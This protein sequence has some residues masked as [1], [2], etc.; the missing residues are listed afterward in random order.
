MKV[1]KRNGT[2][3]PWDFEKIHWRIKSMCSTPF[4][5]DFQKKNR[6]DA[7]EIFKNLPELKNADVDLVSS[8]T[9][10]GLY[11]NIPTSDIDLLSAEI[12]QEMCTKHPD[13]SILA[14]RLRV[15]NLQ[16]NTLE[17]LFEHFSH[18]LKKDVQNNIFKYSMMA[19][20]N[21]KNKHGEISP[22]VAPYVTALA[23][24]YADKLE[25]MID[26]SR[27]YSN[28]DYL[29][30]SLLEKGYLFRTYELENVFGCK[31]LIER[32]SVADMRIAIGIVCAPTPCPKTFP[33]EYVLD[34][35]RNHTEVVKSK[36]W[37]IYDKYEIL[38]ILSKSEDP[39]KHKF[40]NNKLFYRLYWNFQLEEA[41]KQIDVTEE[42]WKRIKEIYDGITTGL[43]TPATPTRFSAGTLKPQ[44]SSCFL[45]AME[46]DSLRGIYNTLQ[47]QS[48]ISKHA[49]GIGMWVHNIRSTGSY[50]AG[51]NGI[52]NGLKP[53]LKVYDNSTRYVDQGGGKRKGTVSC[54]LEPWHADILDF[55][56]LKRNL[57]SDDDHARRLF[58]A[59]WTPD[60]FFRCLSVKGD[61]YLFD[62]AVCPKLYDSYDEGYSTQYLSDEYVNEHK[63]LY[64]FTYRYRK[65]IRQGKYEKKI[66]ILDL[67]EEI[68][69][70]IKDAGNPYMLSKDAANRKSNQKNLGVIKSSNLCVSGDT[71]I[72]TK[73]GYFPII[74][75]V[76]KETTIW[77]G[78]EWSDVT[79]VQ[80]G[81]GQEMA[82]I[83]F[84]NGKVITCTPYHKF[85]INKHNYKCS[86]SEAL[87]NPFIT[88]K[89]DVFGLKVGDQIAT[90]T[91]PDGTV[92]DN[93]KV[94]KIEKLE[95]KMDTYCFKEHKRGTGI[96][97]GIMTGQCTEI[98]QYSDK[99][100]TAVC[101]LHSICL[102]KFLRKSR[103]DD[104]FK[105]N[106]SLTEKED[107][108]SFDFE[109]FA[110]TVR[111]VQNNIDG[112]I[113]T[114]FYPTECAE[115]SNIKHRPMGIGV[116]GEADIMAKL[117]LKWNSREA[118]QLRFY[119][120][121]RLYYEALKA[122]NKLAL[123]SGSYESFVGSPASKGL[124]QFDLWLGEKRK[125]PFPLT[126]NWDKLKK[127]IQE[128]GLRNSL[129]IAPMPTASTSY[130]MGNSPCFEPLKS[131][132][133][134]RKAGTGDVAMVNENLVEDL[135]SLDLW[136]ESLSDELLENH[137][138][139]QDILRI[140][141][142]VRDSYLTA[143]DLEPKDIID[144]A[145][146]RAWFVDQSQSMNLFFKNITTSTLTKALTRGWARGLK[147]L[148]YYC[149]TRKAANADKAQIT[150][151]EPQIKK[152]VEEIPQ[153]C[154]RDDPNCTSC[155]S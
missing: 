103:E 64:Q 126:L 16:K 84:S 76:G 109:Q 49:G 48:Q 2:S 145:Y 29:G 108:W 139:I 25:D 154:Y 67:L 60:E 11:N 31:K 97:N 121:E 45:I 68:V 1:V 3:Q 17:T 142:K 6:P 151:K 147:T 140:P 155:G 122:S 46:D 40:I 130:I 116:Q 42:Q 110:K 52:S 69:T 72:L 19:L 10:Q 71:Q 28:H 127:N 24:K 32:P 27:D 129:F 59:L 115:N 65:Y 36:C 73:D 8:K 152:V 63:E 123:K 7:Y 104:I 37:K 20:Y 56:T 149:H 33:K 120:F 134:V 141:K 34:F 41:I 98:I 18:I 102:N 133:Y 26:Y 15:S 106:V 74:D 82:Q 128:Y 144:A 53:M 125:I 75:L 92:M 90:Y 78:F 143:Y 35:I 77:N 146:S 95:E 93:I 58:Y 113:D 91:L 136:D 89:T 88:E 86:H 132:V 9:N 79:P 87:P 66:K 61:W 153:V 112:L 39:H 114:N 55:L 80:T 148:W 5:L 57:G 13:N 51:T 150:K 100:E 70:T 94:V 111:V 44:G 83:T 135:M 22:L 14:T 119:I 137:G 4:I 138:S 85:Y 23:I 21:N 124:L 107:Y 131:L 43:F 96:F 81:K 101:N 30:I 54:Y 47:K 117:R 99:D 62:P 105:Y 50:I 38:S 118:N 12:A